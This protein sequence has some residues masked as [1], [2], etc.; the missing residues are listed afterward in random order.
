[1]NSVLPF[2][3]KVSSESDGLARI[4]R[5]AEQLV[6]GKGVPPVDGIY[7][8]FTR[9]RAYGFD[10]YENGQWSLNVAQWIAV[11]QPEGE[12]VDEE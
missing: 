10:S 3:L 5:P 6:W 1:M 9:D 8:V 12:G 2:R 7:L 11:P 4:E